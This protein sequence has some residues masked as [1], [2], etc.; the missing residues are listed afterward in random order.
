MRIGITVFKILCVRFSVP[1]KSLFRNP[2]FDP[3]EN[4]INFTV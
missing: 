1:G 2:E 4:I 3:I